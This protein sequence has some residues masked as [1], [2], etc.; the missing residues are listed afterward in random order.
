MLREIAYELKLDNVLN[1]MF[2]RKSGQY[3][4]HTNGKRIKFITEVVF[5][6]PY[7]LAGYADYYLVDF[8]D[9]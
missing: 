4:F 9:Y 8:I 7:G 5:N 6:E 2:R 1:D 3:D